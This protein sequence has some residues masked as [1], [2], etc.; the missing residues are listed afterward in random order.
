MSRRNH[1][2]FWLNQVL[3]KA[4]QW[5]VKN[6]LEPQ[7]DGCGEDFRA[8]LARY[9]EISGPNIR[10]GNHVH[11]TALRDKPVRLSVFEGLGRIDIGSYT[12]V[13]PGV[14]VT[15]ANHV[16][17]GEACMLAMNCYLADADWHDIHH[18]IYAPGKTAP[19]KLGNN[20]WIGDSALVT[21]GVQIGDNSVVGAYSVVTKDVPANT[22]VAGNPARVIKPLDTSHLTTRKDL[23]NMEQS[24]HE[25]ETNYRQELLAGNSFASW[26]RNL[27][28][29][30][31][32]G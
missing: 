12:I 9:L 7:L 14:R 21:K 11:V 22:I 27:V 20:V 15:S 1:Q 24:Y 4:N 16:E 6:R 25:F 5:Y 26:L 28:T 31:K 10:V 23:F 18:R 19:I 29:P 17:I 3:S 32:N 2:P 30:G 13:N 8:I